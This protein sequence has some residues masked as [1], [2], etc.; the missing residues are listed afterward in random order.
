MKY[1]W[2]TLTFQTKPTQLLALLM[3]G[4]L[5][6]AC[7]FCFLVILGWNIWFGF[8][9]FG[10]NEIKALGWYGAAMFGTGW[11]TRYWW[12]EIKAHKAEDSAII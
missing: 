1:L 9:Y 6:L 3:M 12:K 10:W 4:G 2:K 11:A 7:T 5:F 8:E